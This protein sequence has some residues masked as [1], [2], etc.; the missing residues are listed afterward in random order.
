MTRLVA[1][2]A[3][4]L[5]LAA[6]LSSAASAQS[7]N[8]PAGIVELLRQD[9]MSGPRVTA[10]LLWFALVRPGMVRSIAAAWIAYFLPGFHPW[11]HDDRALI[12]AAEAEHLAAPEPK[13]I[14]A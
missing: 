10:R 13:A 12:R 5:S 8:A 2:S 3:L 1:A 6:G 4:A 11:N 14:A 7:Y 9:G